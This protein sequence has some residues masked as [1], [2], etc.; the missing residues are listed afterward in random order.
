[1][2]NMFNSFIKMSPEEL[3]KV[4]TV[5]ELVI[6]FKEEVGDAN[7]T[8]KFTQRPSLNT[9]AE[10]PVGNIVVEGTQTPQQKPQQDNNELLEQGRAKPIFMY[11]LQGTLVRQFDT[12][13]QTSSWLKQNNV[14]NASNKLR[15]ALAE[16]IEVIGYYFKLEANKNNR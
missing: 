16:G 10:T 13:S 4:V 8:L 1:M 12:F 2:Q 7:V 3:R 9:I 14:K 11:D 5:A 15:K 6:K